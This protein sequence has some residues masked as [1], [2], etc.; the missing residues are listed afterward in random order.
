[1]IRRPPR[2]TLSS[3]SAASDVYKRQEY[4]GTDSNMDTMAWSERTSAGRINYVNVHKHLFSNGPEPPSLRHPHP[5]TG[6]QHFVPR[7]DSEPWS[8]Y[9]NAPTMSA[10]SHAASFTGAPTTQTGWGTQQSS[11]ENALSQIEADLRDLRATA[12]AAPPPVVQASS[13]E[14]DALRGELKDKQKVLRAMTE[15]LRRAN[16]SAAEHQTVLECAEAEAKVRQELQLERE[17]RVRAE[18]AARQLMRDAEERSVGYSESARRAQLQNV[19]DVFDLDMDGFIQADELLGIGQMLMLG[20]QG[21]WSEERNAALIEKMDVDKNGKI[22]R[23]EFGLHYHKA[24]PEETKAFDEVINRF[25]H[26]GLACRSRKAAQQ[27]RDAEARAHGRA[28]KEAESEFEQYLRDLD[29]ERAGRLRAEKDAEAASSGKHRYDQRARRAQLGNL[30]GLF[31]LDDDGLI[32]ADELLVIGNELILTQKRGGPSWTEAKNAKLV[33]ALDVNEDGKIDAIEFGLHYEQSFP[34]E[35]E[36]FDAV[37]ERFHRA[38]LNVRNRKQNLAQEAAAV[39]REEAHADVARSESECTRKLQMQ[40][41]K[42]KS[43]T[44]ELAETREELQ[45]AKAKQLGKT[46]RLEE[47]GVQLATLRSELAVSYTHLTLPT[48][49][50]V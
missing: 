41:L 46:R 31:D 2:S 10:S 50:I 38:G 19:F 14:E 29:Q 48:K 25:T 18:S 32:D 11:R 6:S 36:D 42:L 37:V 16:H 5:A 45:E 7:A 23:I 35:N 34:T 15:E 20:Q 3:S 13:T 27:A 1:M 44:T 12:D 24:L 28:S 33:Q 40:A 30:F 43:T 8:K 49:R 26:A 4:G 39:L 17:R 21:S 22:D 9:K 47:M